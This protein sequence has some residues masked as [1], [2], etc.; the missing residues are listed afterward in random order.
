MRTLIR[1]AFIAGLIFAIGV[2]LFTRF[3]LG[4]CDVPLYMEDP[5]IEYMLQP[6]QECWVQRHRIVTNEYGM[7]STSFPR[8]KLSPDEL[9]VLM[10][11]DSIVNG[12][13]HTDH[14]DLGTTDLEN[15]LR[16]ITRRPVVVGNVSCSSWGPPNYR[17]YFRK[18][19]MF[20]ADL[21]IIVTTSGDAQ[22]V[23]KFEPRVGKPAW[24]SQKPLLGVWSAAR[25]VVDR[26][27][28]PHDDRPP[29]RVADHV[30]EPGEVE[31][32]LGAL[33]DVID[34]ARE[35][36]TKVLIAQ[37]LM[38][39]QITGPIGPGHDQI[40]D[41]AREMNVPLTQ[42]GP[43]FAKAIERGIDPYRDWVH[44]NAAGY[45]I[46]VDTLLPPVLEQLGFSQSHAQDPG[47]DD[48]RHGG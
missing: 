38:E 41:V 23:R 27:T 31:T 13:I 43:A 20:D 45:G 6:N 14:A 25:R 21:I 24:P 5:E 16:E 17:A 42:L 11:G 35:N 3:W 33:R 37:H 12:G 26:M 30:P 40:G 2:E 9:R 19:G 48:Q 29:L 46:T 28:R 15:R 39:R 34:M 7:R 1:W 44:P 36:G 47:D 10:V 4:W 18:F 22:D 8:E 32:A